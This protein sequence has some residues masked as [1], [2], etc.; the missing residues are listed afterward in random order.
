VK[1]SV[2]GEESLEGETENKK[3]EIDKEEM[4]EKQEE[5]KEKQE[6]LVVNDNILPL[7]TNE[8]EITHTERK[9]GVGQ[10]VRHHLEAISVTNDDERSA[11]IEARR[12]DG[13]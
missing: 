4:K 12:R 6:D 10:H 8:K 2:S 13:V 9:K 11:V 1:I 5:M 3:D 7:T